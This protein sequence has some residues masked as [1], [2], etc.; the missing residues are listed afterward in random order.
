MKITKSYLKQVIKEE[1]TR[2]GEEEGGVAEKVGNYQIEFSS[3]FGG[4]VSD[5]EV[6]QGAKPDASMAAEPPAF[7]AKISTPEGSEHKLATYYIYR[8]HK[9]PSRFNKN[10]IPHLEAYHES[11]QRRGF[12]EVREMKNWASLKPDAPPEQIKQQA[13]SVGKEISLKTTPRTDQQIAQS[14]ADRYK[15]QSWAQ[16]GAQAYMDRTGVR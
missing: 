10:P 6:P 4:S 1:I 15:P 12:F 2:L 9:K 8:I 13:R 7:V 5:T 16:R 11:S 3:Q 14:A